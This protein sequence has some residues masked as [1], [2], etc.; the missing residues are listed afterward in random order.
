MISSRGV[1]PEVVLASPPHAETRAKRPPLLAVVLVAVWCGLVAGLFELGTILVRKQTIDPNHFYRMS[2]HFVWLVPVTNVCVFT[3]V[4]FLIY[5]AGWA[6]PRRGRWL[7]SRLLCALTFS[8][9]ILIAFPRVYALALFSVTLGVAA[10]VVPVLE[11]HARGFQRFVRASFPIFAGILLVLATSQWAG[12]WFKEFREDG[13]PLPS[14]GSPNVILIVMDTVAASH[15]SLHGYERDT[16]AS[17]VELAERGIRFDSAQAAS[18][19]TLPSHAT[20]F[21]GRW[22]HDLSTGWVNPLDDKWPTLAEYLGARGYATAGFVGNTGYCARDS[23]LGRGFTQ[24]HDYIFPELTAF[25][26]AV[27]VSRAV[28]GIETISE[29]VG[30]QYNLDAVQTYLERQLRRFV[31]DRKAAAVVSGELLQWLSRRKQTERPFLAFLNYDDAHSPYHLQPQRLRRFGSA[32]SDRRQHHLI[33]AWQYLDK[34]LVSPQDLKFVADAYDDCIADL[35]EQLGKLMDELG[36]LKVLDR[37][38]LIITADHGESFGEHAGVFCHGTSLYQTEL[39]VPLLIVPPGG[40]TTK[41]V[42]EETVSLRDL[43]ATIVDILDLETGSPFPGVSLARSWDGATPNAPHP[44]Y[45]FEPALAEVV[46]SDPLDRDVYGLPRKT[47]PMGAVKNDEWSYIRREGDVSEELFHT[48]EDAKEQ[49]NRAGDPGER[50]TLE[51][52]RGILDGLS[53]GPLLPNRFKR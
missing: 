9:M 33:E 36:R 3:A 18:S 26:M 38:W 41:R 43:P 50:S 16:S 30:E 35:D 39:H 25:K 5:L 29:F 37:T 53:A 8:P 51:R 48:R 19:W 47:W 21:T 14:P 15:L 27:L 44:P 52:M 32:P 31:S 6:W 12:D 34:N 42:I 1:L 45:S 11:R 20:M 2:R 10:Q 49:R 17:L 13:R 22:L 7:G 23:G 4:G 40:R 28:A 24:Y 46:P